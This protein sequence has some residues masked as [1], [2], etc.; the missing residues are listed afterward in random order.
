MGKFRLLL[1]VLLFTCGFTV[2]AQWIAGFSPL[3]DL[4]VPDSNC[5]YFPAG[6]SA[7]E[8]LYRQLDT[9][10]QDG[11][12][13]LN[14]L[15]IGGSHVQAGTFSHQMRMRWL[16]L[17]PGMNANRGFLFPYSV[18]KTN[19]PYNYQVKSSGNWTWCKNTQ[20]NVPYL[21]GLS[22][23]VLCA[24]SPNCMLQLRLRNSDIYA[25]FNRIRLFAYSDSNRVEPVIKTRGEVYQGEYD[26]DSR[27]FLFMLDG[28]VD[29]LTLLVIRRDSVWE[30]LYIRGFLL[31]D[32]VPGITYHAVGVNGAS[33]P[34][35][36]QC[37]L[38][39]NDLQ[40]VRPDLCIFGIG[41]N[42][43]NTDQFDSAEFKRRYEFLIDEI[44]QVSPQCK[45]LFITNNDSYR[46]LGR[47]RSSVNRNGELV[48]QAF[49]RLAA[50]YKGAVWD[51]F[52]I[53]GGLGS[54]KKWE[55]RGLVQR[56]KVHFTV[57]GYKYI[58]DL[59][60]T[61]MMNS[62]ADYIKNEK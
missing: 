22:G 17:A 39:M 48:Q 7:F 37:P 50:E 59:L 40:F 4:G 33:V 35:Y 36:L 8:S 23:M 62:Y 55:S 42:D 24:S 53:M 41:I 10:L 27:S 29:S 46:S 32:D 54:V 47:R 13:Q 61:A 58:G 9:L 38:F 52:S 21:M 19:N 28:F 1:W 43:A 57:T 25:D 34:S 56:D 45:F 60:F 15:H 18:A 12:G 26:A 16:Q 31:D 5:L 30:P 2:K 51:L 3:S 49:Y 6:Q 14:I 20:R 11:T 44:L